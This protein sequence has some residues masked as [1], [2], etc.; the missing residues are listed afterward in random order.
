AECFVEQ[1]PGPLGKPIIQCAKEWEYRPADQHV[2]KMSDD[3]KC[4][5]NLEIDRNTRQHDSGKSAEHKNRGKAQHEHKGH[6]QLWSAA[7]ECRQP[8]ENL[9]SARNRD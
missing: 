2:M 5:V 8:A 3:E 4:I 6:P 7:P 9:N 1:P